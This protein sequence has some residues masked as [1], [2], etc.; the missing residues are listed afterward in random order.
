MSS[1]TI[2]YERCKGCL[3]CTAACP[4][5]IIEQTDT[6]NQQGYQVVDV[7]EELMKQCIGCA[8]CAMVCPDFC[9]TV[10]KTPHQKATPKE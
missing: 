9:I 7:P 5:E 3:L 10:Y 4:K 6:F 1:I 8:F 2:R